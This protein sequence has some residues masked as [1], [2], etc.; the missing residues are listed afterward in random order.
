LTNQG[1]TR[2]IG[3]PRPAFTVWLLEQ[4]GISTPWGVGKSVSSPTASPHRVPKYLCQP[5]RVPGK[6]SRLLGNVAVFWRLGKA[7]VIRYFFFFVVIFF[8]T[9]LVTFFAGFFC[10][11]VMLLR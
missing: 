2:P 7:R 8:T 5:V 1:L 9:F 6:P 10:I 11:W 4:W 3:R